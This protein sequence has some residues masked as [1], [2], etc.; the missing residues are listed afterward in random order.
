MYTLPQGFGKHVKLTFQA[1]LFI[2]KIL[3]QI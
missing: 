3:F 2:Y 1:F